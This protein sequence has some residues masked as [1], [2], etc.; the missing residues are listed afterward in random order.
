MRRGGLYCRHV[1]RASRLQ[2][3]V[4][5][6]AIVA[7]MGLCKNRHALLS[8]L[9]VMLQAMQDDL[10][11]HANC[12]TH[13][14]TESGPEAVGVP[15]VE[16]VVRLD[17]DV[18]WR[19][20]LEASHDMQAPRP[21][22]WRSRVRLTPLAEEASARGARLALGAFQVTVLGRRVSWPAPV[23]I[24]VAPTFCQHRWTAWYRHDQSG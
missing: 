21:T 15:G 8:V 12:E 17:A 6:A 19:R 3:S 7:I 18:K 1:V 13:S 23:S 5:P 24:R 2:Y 14:P 16:W 4:N 20:W 10:V 22:S 11:R 9:F